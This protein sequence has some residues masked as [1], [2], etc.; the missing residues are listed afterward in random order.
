VPSL[1][2]LSPPN[3]SQSQEKS[4][5]VKD[6]PVPDLQDNDIL[7]KVAYVAQNPTG[8]SRASGIVGSANV[9]GRLEARRVLGQAQGDRRV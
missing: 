2:A 8:K 9:A 4:A 5:D 1:S 6:H 7:V 3:I